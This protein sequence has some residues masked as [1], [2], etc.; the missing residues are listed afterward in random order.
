MKP[1]WSNE[2]QESTQ[3]NKALLNHFLH[4]VVTTD[5]Q[6]FWFAKRHIFISF[7]ADDNFIL[8]TS[9]ISK[10]HAWW[11]FYITPEK[12]INVRGVDYRRRTN[13]EIPVRPIPWKRY[14]PYWSFWYCDVRNNVDQFRYTVF[15][16][17]VV[18]V[19]CY[20]HPWC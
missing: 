13:F 15:N 11:N 18:A 20:Q 14:V 6:D 5:I 17:T 8:I 9:K 2:A 19:H 12:A 4:E 7:L 10:I 3:A 1:H 16:I